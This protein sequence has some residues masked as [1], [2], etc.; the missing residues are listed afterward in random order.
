MG[1]N[2]GVSGVRPKFLQ[3]R[4]GNVKLAALELDGPQTQPISQKIPAT[5]S[6]ADGIQDVPSWAK[7]AC[8]KIKK[9][10]AGVMKG[11]DYGPVFPF[12]L[13]SAIEKTS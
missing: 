4:A 12:V 5:S 9:G 1:L 7:G 3:D 2:V 10:L 6:P 11:L 8:E 13:A